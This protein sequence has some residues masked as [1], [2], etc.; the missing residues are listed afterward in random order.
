MP[1]ARVQIV[2]E[3]VHEASAIPGYQ[4]LSLG[5]NHQLR[6]D[7]VS[8]LIDHIWEYMEKRGNSLILS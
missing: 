5:I 2:K 1:E 8:S 4:V 6:L 3:Q 7:P